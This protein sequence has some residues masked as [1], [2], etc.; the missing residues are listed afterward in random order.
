MKLGYQIRLSPPQVPLEAS[1]GVA[2]SIKNIN[3]NIVKETVQT[4]ISK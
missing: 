2:A 1:K 4:I 3:L